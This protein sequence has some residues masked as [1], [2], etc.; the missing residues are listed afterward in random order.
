MTNLSC[1]YTLS[2]KINLKQL[3]EECNLPKG[4]ELSNDQVISSLYRIAAKRGFPAAEYENHLDEV[5]DDLVS[6]LYMHKDV[7]IENDEVRNNYNENAETLRF[8]LRLGSVLDYLRKL[9]IIHKF[10]GSYYVSKTT[11]DTFTL[12]QAQALISKTLKQVGLPEDTL[13]VYSLSGSSFRVYL[14]NNKPLET[15]EEF[16]N[17]SEKQAIDS[18][19]GFLQERFPALKGKIHYISVKE[20]KDIL[21]D[22]PKIDID[23]VNSFVKEGEIY[24]LEGRVTRDSAVEEC[25]HPFVRALE[26]GNN[27]LFNH[28]YAS[29]TE[30]FPSL[31]GEVEITY[32]DDKGFTL[33]DRQNEIITK[34]LVQYFSGEFDRI[35][36]SKEGRKSFLDYVKEFLNWFRNLF[37]PINPNTQNHVIEIEDLN[38][39]ATLTDLAELLNLKDIEIQGIDRSKTYFNIK[40]VETFVKSNSKAVC[41]SADQAK[42][43]SDKGFT[44]YEIKDKG[45][46]IVNIPEGIENIKLIEVKD[47]EKTLEDHVRTVEDAIKILNTKVSK[48]ENFE[49]EHKYDIIVPGKSKSVQSTFSVTEVASVLS[50]YEYSGKKDDKGNLITAVGN[51]FDTIVRNFFLGKKS[52]SINSTLS[53]QNIQEIEETLSTKFIPFL[54]KQFGKG[55]YKVITSEMLLAGKYGKDEKGNDQYIAG[56]TDMLI[57][58]DKGDIWIVDMKTTGKDTGLFNPNR[59]RA[60]QTK[61]KY[62]YQLLLYKELLKENFPQLA[63]KVKGTVL[64][65]GTRTGIPESVLYKDGKYYNEETGKLALPKV[66]INFDSDA[67]KKEKNWISVG[68]GLHLETPV[69]NVNLGIDE[70]VSD[71]YIDNLIKQY[72]KQREEK[73]KQV[74]SAVVNTP[75]P[76]GSAI[77]ADDSAIVPPSE[78]T[79]LGRQLMILVSNTCDD[80]SSGKPYAKSRYPELV[81]LE[82]KTASEILRTTN[83]FDIIL[84]KEINDLFNPLFYS[85]DPIME[86]KVKWIRENKKIL[87]NEAIS[88]LINIEHV[89]I[90]GSNSIAVDGEVD[91]LLELYNVAEMEESFREGYYIENREVGYESLVPKELKR[92]LSKIADPN[93]GKKKLSIG[94]E[95]VHNKYGYLGIPDFL[96]KHYVLDTLT[97]NLYMCHSYSAMVNKLNTL[98]T[99]SGYEWM[100]EVLDMLQDDLELQSL[101]VRTFW[102]DKVVYTSIYDSYDKDGNVL[103]NFRILNAQEGRGSI[104]QNWEDAK[105]SSGIFKI[106]TTTEKGGDK[107][108]VEEEWKNKFKD[109]KADSYKRALK[110]LKALAFDYV[111]IKKAAKDTAVQKALSDIILLGDRTVS[112]VDQKVPALI[113]ALLPYY[114]NASEQVVYDNGKTYSTYVEP[115]ELGTILS[116]L[117]NLDSDL[118]D[119]GKLK[120]DSIY[121]KYIYYKIGDT[122]VNSWL[123][124]LDNPKTEYRNLIGNVYANTS[125]LD[126]NF[127][128]QDRRKY[129]INML[130]SYVAPSTG[131]IA[132]ELG[133]KDADPRLALF[134]VPT[135]SDKNAEDSILFYKPIYSKTMTSKYL[136]EK[137]ADYAFHYFLYEIKRMESIVDAYRNGKKDDLVG[138]WKPKGVEINEEDVTIDLFL[139]EKGDIKKELLESGLVF[140]YLYSLNNHIFSKDEN[141]NDDAKAVRDYVLARINGEETSDVVDANIKASFN[142]IFISDM[143][144]RYE[145]FKKLA[146]QLIG[147]SDIERILGKAENLEEFYWNDTIATMNILNLTIQDPAYFKNVIDFQK[148][149]AQMHASAA[150]PNVEAE[151]ITNE[152]SKK[153]YSDDGLQRVVVI[154]DD[155]RNDVET[156]GAEVKKAFTEAAARYPKDSVQRIEMETLAATVPAMFDGVVSTDGQSFASPT[157]FWKKLGMLGEDV[158]GIREIL[159]QIRK[160]NFNFKNINTVVQAF[161]PFVTAKVVKPLDENF[162][163]ELVP[164]QIKNSEAMILLH[165]AIMEGLGVDNNNPV[166]VLFEVMEASAYGD[167]VTNLK[168]LFNE[169]KQDEHNDATYNGRGI[170]TIVFE[171]AVKNG[172]YKSLDLNGKNREEML[173]ELSAILDGD[174]YSNVYVKA[175]PITKWGKQQNNPPH[176]QDSEQPRGSQ[177]TVLSVS[178]IP[179]NA[180]LK[181]NGINKNK[182]TFIEDYLN[183]LKKDY[184]LGLEEVAKVL[185]IKDGVNDK[186]WKEKLSKLLID[187]LNRDG[188]YSKEMRNAFTLINGEFVLPIGDPAIADKVYSTIFN[189]IKKHVNNSGMPGG[190]VVQVSPYAYNDSLRTIKDEKNGG[191]IFEA[192]ITAPTKEIEDLIVT[193]KGK[194]LSPEQVIKNLNNSIEKKERDLVDVK[195]EKNKEKLKRELENLKGKLERFEKAL[196]FIAYRIPTEDK[197]SMFKCRIKGF[198]PRQCG[199]VVILP[200]D[201]VPLSGTDFDIDKLYCMFRYGTPKTERE[202]VRNDIFEHMWASLSHESTKEK[203]LNPGN[204]EVL[205]KLAKDVDPN[206]GNIKMDITKVETQLRLH[207]SNAAGKT[208]V[209]IGALN[210]VSHAISTFSPIKINEEYKLNFNIK[211]GN[212]IVST[213]EG[214]EFSV[215]GNVYS[216][217]DGSRISRTL[218]MFVGASADNAKEAVLQSLNITPITANIAMAMLRYG[219]PL[220]T[221][222]YMLNLPKV[223]K[224]SEK[225]EMEGERF[226]ELLQK[227]K[228]IVQPEDHY[229][230]DEELLSIINTSRTKETKGKSKNSIDSSTESVVINILQ[231]FIPVSKDLS[232]FNQIA[233][234]GSAKNAVG[235]TIYNV[236]KKI[237]YIDYANKVIT[238]GEVLD[239]GD[240]FEKAP[241][242]KPLADCYTKI[243]PNYCAEFSPLFTYDFKRLINSLVVLGGI[244]A[245]SD[246]NIK[247]LLDIYLIFHNKLR[248]A[249][250]DEEGNLKQP[251]IDIFK[252]SMEEKELISKVREGRNPDNTDSY[253][254]FLEKL[255][256]NKNITKRVPNK[257]NIVFKNSGKSRELKDDLAASWTELSKNNPTLSNELL[258]YMFTRFG[259]SWMPNSAVG[260]APNRVKLSY[261]YNTLFNSILVVDNNLDNMQLSTLLLEYIKNFLPYGVVKSIDDE[262]TIV[263]GFSKYK[264]KLY[265][266]EDGKSKEQLNRLGIPNQFIEVNLEDHE[267]S[268]IGGNNVKKQSNS[269][270]QKETRTRQ[271][272]LDSTPKEIKKGIVSKSKNIKDITDTIFEGKSEETR[273][274][275]N[276]SVKDTI[277]K[278]N[279]CKKK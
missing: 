45:L 92:R 149:F 59:D 128:E 109:K 41:V 170:D 166:S 196:D 141:L 159:N 211:V 225:A 277:K 89:T 15:Y 177:I 62:G 143:N 191:Y 253:N 54:D 90:G 55:R 204:F 198:L 31:K 279:L 270:S 161:K 88:E 115:S 33:S 165:G 240:I 7:Y 64:L 49:I 65:V 186:N 193:E 267:H 214:N 234:L 84:E 242:L 221:V 81:N 68:E 275:V 190:P 271:Q 130:C 144:S 171:S 129:L 248:Q 58:T 75:S 247:K 134:R 156:M 140:R 116:D 266:S 162:G 21:K 216:P 135:M 95:I 189:V 133:L 131:T 219:V 28:L 194:M 85:K 185:G 200:R 226:E 250:T 137:G 123:E 76:E 262:K 269:S 43:L 255:V 237:A 79:Y 32:T 1:I 244:D 72:D 213:S 53:R 178:D 182:K 241:H 215:L 158:T 113:E 24:L 27:A 102:K 67:I 5:Y 206:F 146:Y 233:S 93:S 224:I 87:I 36:S 78:R 14:P 188:R 125:T 8:N 80:I 71:A 97:D 210:N 249:I 61:K 217:F 157:A 274:L 138:V 181:V 83:A 260:I 163:D 155:V 273:E 238:E 230:S 179:E 239:F 228:S 4:V 139:D 278:E 145:E 94:A 112:K 256:I 168:H 96:D 6:D 42:K 121:K 197:Y 175:Y 44:V 232:A 12:E 11:N 104:K 29:A 184:E 243:V 56:A 73:R 220:K 172:L 180:T 19:T 272:E 258:E 101:F 142:N 136:H 245:L 148:R 51:S 154:K 63:E 151:F 114:S 252:K 174:D 164:I 231:Q 20:A 16:T 201:I 40:E 47:Q 118:Y 23:D 202:N 105:Y 208:F 150:K 246:K 192:Y 38:N 124:K 69:E 46:Y 74:S 98:K 107:L 265:F 153:R 176:M 48:G 34:A 3:S 199:E 167:G 132:K 147:E 2:D 108:I 17:E 110:T 254:P 126:S 99:R 257:P 169:E 160:G 86:N 223:K 152:G 70:I 10:Q 173:D 9:N 263:Q 100:Q 52:G 117:S 50:E 91:G 205:K 195:S 259:F 26:I 212:R 203:A 229:I 120:E 261:G 236:I 106:E 227:A 60:N 30:T 127:N 183:L 39:R 37:A 122:W 103:Y 218:G 268:V 25:L 57:V 276:N 251:E 235:P 77:I 119:D 13:K 35:E 222:V 82:G 111:D 66:K 22:N 264:N 207:E 209:G 18:I 187:S